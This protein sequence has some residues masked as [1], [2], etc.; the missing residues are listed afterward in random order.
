M[1]ASINIQGAADWSPDGTWV[2]VGGKDA[3]G[4]G[5]F[6]IA[7]AGGTPRRLVSGVAIDPAWSPN[8]EFIVYAG[9]FA[10]GTAAVRVPGAPL[11]AIRPDGRPY[12][13]PQVEQAGAKCGSQGQP[14]RLPLSRR[15]PPGLPARP[16]ATDFWL[17]NLV[18]GERRQLTSL[19]NKG[20]L[21]GFDI[22]PD[23]THIVFDRVR[24]NGDIILIERQK[25]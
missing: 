1:A 13:L 18:S 25:K 3:D 4:E 6:L 19:S 12:D 22:T 2:A 5:L 7:A 15:D 16:E 14:W 8:G 9:P 23:G 17:F 21:R 24:Q 20:S 10:G 11:Q